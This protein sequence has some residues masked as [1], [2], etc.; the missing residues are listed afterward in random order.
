MQRC[1]H[2]Q[3]IKPVQATAPEQ[4]ILRHILNVSWK[5]QIFQVQNIAG[6]HSRLHLY[7]LVLLKI[8]SVVHINCFLG[9]CKLNLIVY[10]KHCFN[11]FI[12]F[13]QILTFL[14]T[15]TCFGQCILTRQGLLIF[16]KDC[17]LIFFPLPVIFGALNLLRAVSLLSYF[18]RQ[19][20]QICF[21]FLSLKRP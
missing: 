12:S 13:T 20:L 8:S 3:K 14:H 5:S 18:T 11:F 1:P 21:A 7:D 9:T 6:K 2:L 4:P 19:L 16:Q 17:H 10:S 15:H